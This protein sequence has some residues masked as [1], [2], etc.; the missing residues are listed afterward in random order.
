MCRI[1]L[2]SILFL[3]LL[4]FINC[5][6]QQYKTEFNANTE[7]KNFFNLRAGIKDGFNLSGAHKIFLKRNSS[8]NKKLIDSILIYSLAGDIDRVICQYDNSGKM[9]SFEISD[10]KNNLWQKYIRFEY[11]YYDSGLLKSAIQ[12]SYFNEKWENDSFEKYYYDSLNQ[13]IFYNIGILTNGL[14]ILWKLLNM[15]QTEILN[16]P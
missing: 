13:N 12:K 14:I 1:K 8:S 16:K 3:S 11:E 6:P 9:I 2:N 10:R 15:I 5:Y 7:R 4:T